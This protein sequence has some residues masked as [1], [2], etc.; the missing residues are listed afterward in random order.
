MDQ[1]LPPQ[2]DKVP[3]VK[4]PLLEAEGVKEGSRKED[5]RMES[6]GYPYS[7]VERARKVQEV[8]LRAID[9]RLKW[10]QAAEI[11]GISDRQMRRWKQ[12][13]EQGGYDGLFDRRRHQPSP[14][15]VPLAVVRQVLTLDRE[16]YFDLTVLHF[17]EKL[18][19]DRVV[20][21][22]KG[23]RGQ[24]GC[25]VREEAGHAPDL[26]RHDGLLQRKRGK[27]GGEALGQHRLAG[28]R[29]ADE[30]DIVAAATSRARF[31]CSCPFTSP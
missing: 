22:S 8:I 29:W 14:K 18:Q 24:E 10:Y 5:P 1:L 7:A 6:R 19:G 2:V 17:H 3:Q 11:L 13:D 16:R 31:A 4:C 15:R 12:R 25:S 26:G 30:E 28:T 21:G 27:D 20:G 23:P 9:G